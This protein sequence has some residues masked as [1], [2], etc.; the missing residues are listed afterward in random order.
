MTQDNNDAVQHCGDNICGP[1]SG[2]TTSVIFRNCGA[3]QL[4]A[5]QTSSSVLADAFG[6]PKFSIELY[7]VDKAYGRV[8][9]REC[10]TCTTSVIIRIS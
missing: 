6:S 10:Q 3:P 7:A 2:R 8:W 5:L 1:K 4:P 9:N